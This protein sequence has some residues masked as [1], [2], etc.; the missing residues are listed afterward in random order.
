MN[1]AINNIESIEGLDRCESLTT[2]DLTLNFIPSEALPQ[3]A[4]L[5][6]CHNL[7][8]LSL[9][10]NPC[11]QW[12]GYRKYTVAV[13]PSL[14]VLDGMEVT[15]EERKDALDA[16]PDMDRQ[17]HELIASKRKRDGTV[18]CKSNTEERKKTSI[19]SPKTILNRNDGSDKDGSMTSTFKWTPC[20]RLMEQM[21]FEKKEKERANLQECKFGKFNSAKQGD[22]VARPKRLQMP[23]IEEDAEAE[24]LQCNE[25]DWEFSLI[26][27]TDPPS[28]H[29]SLGPCMMLKVA[30]ESHLDINNVEIDVHPRYVRL[31]A[32]GRLLQV[33]LPSEVYSSNAIAQRSKST[34]QLHIYLPI[35]GKINSISDSQQTVLHRRRNVLLRAS[36]VQSIA[37][38]QVSFSQSL[39]LARSPAV[40]I[41]PCSNA[42]QSRRTDVEFPPLS[43]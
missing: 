28:I 6:P 11:T 31:L 15:D 8:S 18:K 37:R 34:G 27:E 23:K 43:F 19:G 9:M 3:L 7:H 32:R 20:M 2:L 14:K 30:L 36:K 39:D 42:K 17:L 40:V 21:E 41:E 12:K 5:L 22:A 33:R 10:G 16:R 25:G 38:P 35:N 13:L 4:H 24:L 26:E 29:S 1:L